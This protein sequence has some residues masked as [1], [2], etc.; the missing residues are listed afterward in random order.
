LQWSN[1]GENQVGKKCR[2]RK[3]GPSL[4]DFVAL[5]QAWAILRPC[6]DLYILLVNAWAISWPC[7]FSYF[8]RIMIIFVQK[9][10]KFQ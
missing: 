6:T 4:G 5:A 10:L 9:L 2:R 7:T 1:G 3:F 8:E